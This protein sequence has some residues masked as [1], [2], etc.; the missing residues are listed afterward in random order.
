M[1]MNRWLFTA[2]FSFCLYLVCVDA[3]FETMRGMTAIL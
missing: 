1:Y 3:P 2:I